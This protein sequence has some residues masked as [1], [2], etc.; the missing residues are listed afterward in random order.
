[1]YA[2]FDD[3]SAEYPHSIALHSALT[4]LTSAAGQ[5]ICSLHAQFACTFVQQTVRI[6][7]A[8]QAVKHSDCESALLLNALYSAYAP[9]T[10]AQH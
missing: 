7:S 10:P 1:M 5:T 8:V 2:S 3:V 9:C 6:I 4:V